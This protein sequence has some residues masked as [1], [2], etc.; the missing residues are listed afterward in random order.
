MNLIPF[1]K[2]AQ[3]IKVQYAVTLKWPDLFLSFKVTANTEHLILP[4]IVNPQSRQNELWNSTCFEFFLKDSG[5]TEY[6]EFN[7]SPSGSWNFYHLD[8]YRQGLK[9]DS[10]IPQPRFEREQDKKSLRVSSV[11]HF[12]KLPPMTN[13]QMGIS[14][15]LAETSG[16]KSYWALKHPDQKPNFHHLESFCLNPLTGALL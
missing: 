15:V 4:D 7:L 12:G 10:R 9:E 6:F 8:S 13:P 11:I 16:N 5:S 1:E 2:P 14:A 3:P